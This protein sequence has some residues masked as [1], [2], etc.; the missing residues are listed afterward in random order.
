MVANLDYSRARDARPGTECRLRQGAAAIPVAVARRIASRRARTGRSVKN[1]R[2]QTAQTVSSITTVDLAGSAGSRRRSRS[3]SPRRRWPSSSRSRSPSAGRNSRRWP[4]SEPRCAR[5][6]RS[7]GRRRRS[8][9]AASIALA[10]LLGWLL[11]EMLVAMLQHVFDPP[12]D[13]LAVPW[14]FL[15]GSSASPSSA[16]PSPPRRRR[17]GSGGCRSA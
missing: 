10:A 11:A 15:A 9:V 3:C 2:Q 12:P 7:S 17:S 8:F 4:R 1:I 16:P 14:A 6:R 13:H 5:S